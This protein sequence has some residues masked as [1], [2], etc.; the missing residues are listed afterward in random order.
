[1]LAKK[2]KQK[3]RFSRVICTEGRLS[4]ATVQQ[5][6]LIGRQ[7]GIPALVTS[8]VTQSVCIVCTVGFTAIVGRARA[9][10][11]LCTTHQTTA[12]I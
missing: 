5:T 10:I 4:V 2:R 11:K 12:V 6:A 1:M 7:L 8:S 3:T 9:V